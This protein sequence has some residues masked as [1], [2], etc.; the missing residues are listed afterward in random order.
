MID[1]SEQ[2]DKERKYRERQRDQAIK[3]ITTEN[4]DAYIEHMDLI[5]LHI[6]HT[7]FGFGASRLK[8]VYQLIDKRYE[9]YR[10]YMAVNDK[11]KFNDGP[12]RDDT[13]TLKDN[14]RKIGFDYDEEVR[15]GIENAKQA[16]LKAQSEA[17]EAYEK[18]SEE[19]KGNESEAVKAALQAMKDYAKG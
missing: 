8:R 7:E 19:L 16:T 3:R 13:A 6:L 5:V 12:E 18:A 1:Y 17:Q 11:T 9:E 14:L 10:R 2:F 4:C 15:K